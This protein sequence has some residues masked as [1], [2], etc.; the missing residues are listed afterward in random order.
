MSG[1]LPSIHPAD[2]PEAP[3]EQLFVKAEKYEFHVSRVSFLGFVVAASGLQLASS[4]IQ[5]SAAEVVRV[6]QLLPELHLE[7]QVGP[8]F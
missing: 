2:T 7:L 5:K 3:G 8:I 1:R 4:S 6:H